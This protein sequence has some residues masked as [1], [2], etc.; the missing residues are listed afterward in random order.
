MNEL[1]VPYGGELAVLF[2]DEAR[3]AELREAAQSMPSVDLFPR[4][5]AELE[6]LMNG[7]YSPL[8][9]YMG[10]ADY[11]RVLKE[12]R[13]ADGT[14]W[15]APVTLDVGE[16]PAEKLAVGQSLALRDLEGVLLAVL[17]I[18]DIWRPDLAA[19][20]Q[21]L[22][23]TTDP[24]HPGVDQL[25]TRIQP[26]YV[27]GRVEGVEPMAQHSFTALRHSPAELRY[28]FAKRG[29]VQVAA[30]HTA[31]PI[32]AGQQHLTMQAVRELG[33]NLLL[34]PVVEEEDDYYYRVRCYRAVLEHYPQQT[35]LLSLL[36]LPVRGGGVRE[37]LRHAIVRRNFGCSHLLWESGAFQLD[38]GALQDAIDCYG[39]ELG[40]QLL[41]RE[42]LVY[43]EDSADF[44]PSSQVPAG[45]RAL[46]L[47]PVELQRRLREGLEI[48]AWFSYPEVIAELRAHY[49]PRS[50]QGLTLFFTGLSGSGKSTIAKAVLA[51]LLE[52]G[53]RPVSL[54]DGD[55]VRKNLSSELGFSKEHRNLN[56]RR[57]GYVASEIT[58]NGGIAICAPIAPYTALR[59]EV[60]QMISQYGRFIEIHV[61]TSL[62][63][64]EG[65][66]RKG[67]YAKARAGI[68]KE[69]T[70]ISDPYEVP[71]N[72]ELRIDTD[73]LSVEEAAQRVFLYLEQQG[74][75]A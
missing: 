66:D 24:A 67:L 26:V 4:Q 73:G 69:F 55:V 62:A 59:R 47:S 38:S 11:G 2:A 33:V 15:P 28:Q 23:G 17:Y 71:E 8:R 42:P 53:G 1:I 44:L 32:H 70:G 45:A 10:Q 30:F 35:T 7:A 61:A 57:I 37:L 20:A 60:R 12:M 75:I 50:K 9:G 68:I 65:R 43:V 46:S 63:V 72:P 48:P 51:K 14:L 64:C 5:Q 49:P 39:E 16:G 22:Y 3:A 54:L 36:S 74:Y 19:E 13:L 34:H 21:V 41:A 18:E 25:L 31:V 29:W 40:I 27:G 56:I 6:L 52:L 58:K